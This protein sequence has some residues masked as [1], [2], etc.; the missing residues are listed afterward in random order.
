MKHRQNYTS[1][2][3]L[4]KA[5]AFAWVF[6]FSCI[7]VV[8]QQGVFANQE[9]QGS[10]AAGDSARTKLV[11]ELT[12]AEKRELA[13]ELLEEGDAY[14]FQK[15]YEQANAV[16]EQVFLLEPNHRGASQR[17]DAL[18]KIMIQ[19][20]KTEI[21]LLKSVYEDEIDLR[22]K[23]YWKDVER[24]TEEKRPAQ[25]RFALEKIL[26]IDPFNEE[27]NRKYQGLQAARKGGG[28]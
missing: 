15:N 11:E 13:N 25:A 23:K 22:V 18:K 26:L 16:Y 4:K 3:Q 12:A 5:H 28:E 10:A 9:W 24:F 6:L 2:R 14:M 7:S 19:E 27:A 17:L 8:C 21:G 20:G 1:D